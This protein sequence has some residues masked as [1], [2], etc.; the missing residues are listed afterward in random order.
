MLHLLL[1]VVKEYEQESVVGAN[2][3]GG[4]IRRHIARMIAARG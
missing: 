2:R 3:A 1:D 4:H